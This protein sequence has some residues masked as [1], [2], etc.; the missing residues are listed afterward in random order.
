ML[1]IK[2]DNGPENS[3]MR[4]QSLKRMVDWVDQ[5]GKPVQLLLYY[6]HYHS[7][8]NLI[9]RCWGVLEQHWNGTRLIDIPT[10][11][12]WAKSMTWK[13]THPIIDLSL[14]ICHRGIRLSKQHNMRPIEARLERNPALPKWDILIRPS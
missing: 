9:E 8:Y 11:L 14:L 12:V 2:V 10:M 1:Q 4:T 3:G 6:P 13:D 5:I 7:K